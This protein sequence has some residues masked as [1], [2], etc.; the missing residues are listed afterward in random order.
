LYAETN[1]K[2]IEKTAPVTIK[3]RQQARTPFIENLLTIKSDK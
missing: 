1:P 2:I 3:E